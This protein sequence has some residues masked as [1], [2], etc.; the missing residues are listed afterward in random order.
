MEILLKMLLESLNEI[1]VKG[2]ANHAAL[3][4]CITI[5]KKLQKVVEGVK[6]N[7]GNHE[8]EDIPGEVD[9]PSG[10]DRGNDG[11]D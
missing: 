4:G 6:Q 8:G 3:L 2:E 9:S 11:C 1:E 10:S 5:V 7:D